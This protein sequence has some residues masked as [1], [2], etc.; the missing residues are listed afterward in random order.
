MVDSFLHHMSER[1]AEMSDVADVGGFLYGSFLDDRRPIGVVLDDIEYDLLRLRISLAQDMV[2]GTWTLVLPRPSPSRPAS[3]DDA[4]DWDSR[5][6]GAVVNSP[7]VLDAVL[8]HFR[9]TLKE[10]LALTEG[11]VLRVPESAM[12]MLGLTA[13][14]GAHVATGR[15]GQARGFRAV[16]LTADPHAGTPEQTRAAPTL[17][18]SKAVSGATLTPGAK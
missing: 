16:R 6:A 3:L 8:C 2:V 14:G 9:L 17:R 4:D 10:A 7:V 1:C 12:E 15:L 11:D 5:L 18:L 13:I